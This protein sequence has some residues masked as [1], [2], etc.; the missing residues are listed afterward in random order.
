LSLLQAYVQQNW[1]TSLYDRFVIDL[2]IIFNLYSGR[3][4]N[5]ISVLK[6]WE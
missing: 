5:P 3:K 4:N 2:P 1:T 6:S